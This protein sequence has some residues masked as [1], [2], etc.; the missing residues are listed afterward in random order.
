MDIAIYGLYTSIFGLGSAVGW[1]LFPFLE[2]RSTG[3]VDSRVNQA[4]VEL[5]DMFLNWDPAR[6]RLFY[7]LT[8]VVCGLLAWMLSG[9]LIGLVGGAVVGIVLLRIWLRVL[10][11]QRQKKF[12]GMLVDTLLLI[13]SCVRAGLSM[14]QAFTVV[15]EEMPA[16]A[17]QEIGLLLKEIRMGVSMEDALDH[18]RKRMP[19]E[20]VTLF[21]TA[22]LVARETGGDITTIFT[23]LVETL[24]ERKKIKEKILTLTFMAKAQGLVMAMLPMIFMYIVY[25]MDP[26]H[27]RFFFV[28]PLG[29]LF[30]AGVVVAQ[31][32]G[33][34]LFFRFSR[35]PM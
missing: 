33:A 27:V 1:Y 28:D 29:Q 26:S 12:Q 7:L 16:P 2:R 18:F 21:V 9:M 23:K 5:Q 24:R 4:Q 8:P 10:H 20:E 22:V 17:S 32:I 15:A 13:S 6:L 3:F 31:L 34:F 14:L 11:A 19:S 35:S 25:K 30:F